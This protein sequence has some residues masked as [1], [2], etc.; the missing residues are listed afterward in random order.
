MTLL[1]ALDW[2][3]A[4]KQFADEK[5]SKVELKERL[6]ATRSSASSYGLQLYNIIVLESNT[7]RS[8]LLPF[9]YGQDNIANS[10]V[11]LR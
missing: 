7:T 5:I 3:Y 8:Q 10:G 2:R 9:S 4:V 6:N 11:S 1:E